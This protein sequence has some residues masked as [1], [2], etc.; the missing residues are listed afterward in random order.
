MEVGKIVLGAISDGTFVARPGY[1]GDG[2]AAE[3]HGDL[4]DRRG[5]RGSRSAVS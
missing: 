1:F 3:G 4:F 2:A 5:Q